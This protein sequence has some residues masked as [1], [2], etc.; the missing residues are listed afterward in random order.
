VIFGT[1]KA[2]LGFASECYA[3]TAPKLKLT[4]HV[5]MNLVDEDYKDEKALTEGY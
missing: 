5:R 4:I 2:A 1:R 3:V